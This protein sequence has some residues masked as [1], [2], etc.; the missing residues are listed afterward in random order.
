MQ[1]AFFD[2]D[3]T[4][5]T[6]DTFLEFIKYTHGKLQFYLGFLIVS[7]YLILYKLGVIPNWKAK[8]KV[9]TY[10]YKGDTYTSLKQIGKQFSLHK[11]PQLI[12]PAALERIK[13]HQAEGHKVLIISAS[14]D[15]WLEAWCNSL[16]VELIA[17]HLEVI[18]GKVTGKLGCVN[19]YGAEKVNRIKKAITLTDY[20]IIH[21]YG[22]SRGDKEMLELSHKRYYKY[23]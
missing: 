2:F 13:W 10:F 23:F 4:I 16:N 6:K 9:I 12:R 14:V 21:A 1:I 8:E 7:P 17:T 22:D 11:I 19:C 15:I 20:E 3:G 18:Q 5:T